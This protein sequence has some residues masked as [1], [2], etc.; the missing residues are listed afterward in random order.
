MK[1]LD[2]SAH[3][4]A[5]NRN[6]YVFHVYL[7][8]AKDTRIDTTQERS[9]VR[10]AIGR[11]QPP[12]RPAPIRHI[13]GGGRGK[14]CQ[15][16]AR[17][18]RQRPTERDRAFPPPQR[19]TGDSPKHLQ[20]KPLWAVQLASRPPDHRRRALVPGRH[21]LGEFNTAPSPLVRHHWT[22]E[23]GERRA[24]SHSRPR[25][26]PTP[27]ERGF[28]P[29]AHPHCLGPQR[30]PPAPEAS[31]RPQQRLRSSPRAGPGRKSFRARTG[32][33]LSL[34]RFSSYL[35]R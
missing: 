17:S 21:V 27:P 20:A 23:G 6:W 15:G 24:S 3:C 34:S 26:P 10:R 14:A 16:R 35:L 29:A 4:P 22:A 31:V 11:K 7:Q 2:P 28:P 12:Q 1:A 8:D 32:A 13:H 33:W 18:S 19:L 30:P 25:T 5:L 9:Q